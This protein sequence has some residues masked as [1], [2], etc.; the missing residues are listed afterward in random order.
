MLPEVVISSLRAKFHR[1]SRAFRSVSFRDD[2]TV[3]CEQ[4]ENL[5]GPF[6][7]SAVYVSPPILNQILH[8]PAVLGYSV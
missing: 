4:R 8:F 6:Y 3:S 7:N 2:R 1:V 5:Y